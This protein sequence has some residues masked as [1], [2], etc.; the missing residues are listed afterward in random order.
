MLLRPMLFGAA[1]LALSLCLARPSAAQGTARVFPNGQT[2]PI[3][4]RC[5]PRSVQPGGLVHV[6]I[7]SSP[8]YRAILMGSA[9]YRAAFFDIFFDEL[10]RPAF[11]D[12][13]TEFDLQK[14]PAFFDVFCEVNVRP[15]D[16]TSKPE[17]SRLRCV[18]AYLTPISIELLMQCPASIG[19]AGGGGGLGGIISLRCADG[20]CATTPVL[21][22]SP[23]SPIQH[24]L[25]SDQG[26]CSFFD[27]FTELAFDGSSAKTPKYRK[28][29]L[30]QGRLLLDL[31][32]DAEMSSL[33]ALFSGDP[34]LDLARSGHRIIM[35]DV[36]AR[37]MMT[38]QASGR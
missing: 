30:Q 33:A 22:E 4:I 12:V 16:P 19:G 2:I 15:W 35:D 1:A 9:E 7:V 13:F 27:V 31:G 20:T 24:A 21:T 18:C 29:L 23:K 6:S 26:I 10:S 25:C 11:F 32:G 36:L 8:E 17:V 37:E 28:V 34:R 3:Q 5:S 38:G 14:R